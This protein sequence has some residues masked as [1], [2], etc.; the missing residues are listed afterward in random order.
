M[1]TQPPMQAFKGSHILLE[2]SRDSLSRGR[3]S[4]VTQCCL[5]L[6][7]ETKNSREGD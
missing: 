2:R 5:A 7:D 4:I 3:L 1:K 6:R